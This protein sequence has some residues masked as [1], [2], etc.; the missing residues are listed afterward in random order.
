MSAPEPLRRD[1]GFLGSAFL[2]F[3]GLVGAAIFV[4]PGTL[5]DRFGDFSPLLFPLFGGLALLI[6]LPF[7]RVASHFGG[8]GGPVAY[9]ATF[10]PFASFQAA[11]TRKD[12]SRVL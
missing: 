4:L 2:S 10:G 1:I 7:A 6:A 12:M 3:N 5:D 11:A 9:A 8:T